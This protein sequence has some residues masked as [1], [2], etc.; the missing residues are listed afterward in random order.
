MF[1]VAGFSFHIVFRQDF[2]IQSDIFFIGGEIEK[3]SFILWEVQMLKLFT[4]QI[5]WFY[6]CNI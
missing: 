4:D 3:R 5:L 1:N 2:I 6:R